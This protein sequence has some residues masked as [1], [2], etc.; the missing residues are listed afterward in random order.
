L[1]KQLV[2]NQ[3]MILTEAQVVALEKSKQEKEAHRSR[4]ASF[5]STGRSPAIRP[6]D[7]C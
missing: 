3:C 6:S 4:V 7:L 1:E 2:A 5:R